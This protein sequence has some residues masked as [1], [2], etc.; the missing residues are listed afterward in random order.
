MVRFNEP[1]WMKSRTKENME[2]MCGGDDCR[3]SNERNVC[4]AVDVNAVA[5]A[6]AAA[7]ALPPL[8][9]QEQII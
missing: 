5:I 9:A 1:K 7:A 3:W 2:R 8:L 6:A 4:S